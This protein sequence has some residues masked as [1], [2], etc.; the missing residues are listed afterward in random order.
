MNALRWHG[1]RD[2][3]YQVVE[4]APAP[5]PDEARIR[6]AY[7]GICG[8][9]REEYREG[10]ILIPVAEPHPL[11]HKTAPL[12]LGHEFSGIVESVGV[13]VTQLAPGDHVAADVL[14]HCGHCRECLRHQYNLCERQAALGLMADGGW[15]TRR[16]ANRTGLHLC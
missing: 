13:N 10:P 11:T 14:I 5:G 16:P 8:T 4:D 2:V 12:I 15:R 7:A 3:R 1:R 9:D 6:V